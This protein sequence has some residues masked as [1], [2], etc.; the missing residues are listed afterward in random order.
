MNKDF[1]PEFIET[2]K[3]ELLRQKGYVEE[4]LKHIAKCD[5]KGGMEECKAKFPQFGDK[6]ED[7][8]TE[9]DVYENY[10]SLEGNLETLVNE[11]DQA[12][13]KIAK[14]TYGQCSN[15]DQ[16]IPEERLEAFPAA[17]LCLQ[18]KSKQEK[19]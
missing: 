5:L 16:L 17:P 1:S 6:E 11:V 4:E 18:C 8:A 3:K 12:L 10:T 19:K 2:R 7:N 15:C 9:V 13:E 14:G